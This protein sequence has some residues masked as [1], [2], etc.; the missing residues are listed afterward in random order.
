MASPCGLTRWVAAKILISFDLLDPGLRCHLQNLG[1]KEIASNM[2][3]NR[4]HGAVSANENRAEALAACGGSV[5]AQC[6][7]ALSVCSVK[8]VRHKK[9]NSFC[10][11][12]WKS[13]SWGLGGACP[14]IGGAGVR[15]L[16]FF[17]KNAEGRGIRL[18]SLIL[19]S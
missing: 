19:T 9:L 10:G 15:R 7:C 14:H 6:D 5:C 3:G 16:P 18:V 1:N 17:C 2:L 4:S 12:L 8:V 13:S 11:E